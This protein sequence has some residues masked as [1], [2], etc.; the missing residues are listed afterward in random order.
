MPARRFDLGASGTQFLR[1]FVVG[2]A[3]FILGAALLLALGKLGVHPIAAQAA[4][5]VVCVTATWW[6]NRRWS[7]A[8][9]AP[10]NLNEYGRYVAASAI[11][12]AMNLA[13]FAVTLRISDSV[14][15]AY[16]SATLVVMAFN[17]ASYKLAIFRTAGAAGID[18]GLGNASA[19]ADAKADLLGWEQTEQARIAVY[20]FDRTITAWPTYSHFLLYGA[21]QIS[22]P[23][24]LLAPLL[25]LLMLCYLARLVNR[26]RLKELMWLVM[27]GRLGPGRLDPAIVGFARYT[28]S[29]NIR[30]GALRQIRADRDADAI[31]ILATAAHGLYAKPIANALG[32]DFVVA[33][34]CA[35][36]V[37]G[38]PGPAL[39]GA[40]VHGVEKLEAIR[41]LLKTHEVERGNAF[42]T[43]YSDS[44]ADMP[45]FEW[46]DRPVAVNPSRRLAHTAKRRRWTLQDWGSGVA[47]Q[48][49]CGG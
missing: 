18:T 49:Q 15:V 42:I 14:L 13:I 7:F 39:G 2:A 45:V 30:P 32:F 48:G 36:N 41:R 12:L 5:L 33:T 19:P 29:R 1:F 35:T 4:T 43:F 38:G 47:A 37:D 11:G 24:L 21:R 9:E 6:G 44:M 46:C 34:P 10:P 22:A 31:L 40:N 23:R 17:F 28:L 25:P 20:D 3:A 27:L 16:T 26:D 8:V